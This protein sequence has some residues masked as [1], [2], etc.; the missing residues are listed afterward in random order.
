MPYDECP[1]RIELD[2]ISQIVYSSCLVCMLCLGCGVSGF[3]VMLRPAYFDYLDYKQI[4]RR[5][6]GRVH[7]FNLLINDNIQEVEKTFWPV[8]GSCG[9]CNGGNCLP[10]FPGG[11]GLIYIMLL[12]CCN[13][14]SMH[15]SPC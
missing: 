14:L 3:C 13:H 6:G 2:C 8:K 1:T 5:K 15:I 11:W 4:R 10:G 12:H 9:G 7:M